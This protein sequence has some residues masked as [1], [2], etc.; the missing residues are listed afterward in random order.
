MCPIMSWMDLR[1]D[2]GFSAYSCEEN[3]LFK[4]SKKSLD[5]QPPV[6]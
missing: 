4:K 6:C 2:R 1:F 3:S 5:S